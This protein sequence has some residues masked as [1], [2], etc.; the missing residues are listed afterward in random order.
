MTTRRSKRLL[1]K[2]PPSATESLADSPVLNKKRKSALTSNSKKE[3]VTSRSRVRKPSVEPV[4][5]F[6]TV[7]SSQLSRTRGKT[8]SSYFESPNASEKSESTESDY[9]SDSEPV[10]KRTPKNTNNVSRSKKKPTYESETDYSS[11]EFVKPRTSQT[12]ML[13]S[14]LVDK[15]TQPIKKSYESESDS[16]SDE[17]SKHCVRKESSEPAA[18]LADELD[19]NDTV[20]NSTTAEYFDFA[21]LLSQVTQANNEESTADVKPVIEKQEPKKNAPT[22]VK[23]S[24][25]GK[26]PATSTQV[27]QVKTEQMEVFELLAMGE[28]TDLSANDIK[29]SVSKATEEY[30]IPKQVEVLLDA[31]LVKKKKRCDDLEMALRRRLNNIRR[32]NQVYIHKVHAL[33]WIAHGNHVNS[34]L[35]SSDV[36]GLALSLLPSEKCYPPKRMNM[37]YL[38]DLINWFNK[39]VKLRKDH[40]DRTQL[41]LCVSLQSQLQKQEAETKLDLCFMFICVIRALG[42][43]CRLVINLNV[44]PI[45]PTSEQLLPVTQKKEDEPKPKV[46]VGET[47]KGKSNQSVQSIQSTKSSNEKNNERR[48]DKPKNEKPTKNK[49]KTNN[50][51]TEV[52]EKS[53]NSKNVK[54]QAAKEDPKGSRRS[55]RLVNSKSEYFE[56]EVSDEEKVDKKRTSRTSKSSERAG[57]KKT[58]SKANK[59]AKTEASVEEM[60]SSD[61]DFDSGDDFVTP[62]KKRDRRVLSSED[63]SEVKKPEVKS[64]KPQN[65]INYWTEV[66]LEAEEKWASVDIYK[67]SYLCDEDLYVSIPWPGNIMNETWMV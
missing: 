62:K 25:R 61:P 64:N 52:K 6:K 46:N 1:I 67:K 22:P 4:A 11:D 17:L 10:R 53:K 60:S 44:A 40:T 36:L 65:K 8:K 12:S 63:E 24:R 20:A 21:P 56:G 55:T 30:E 7:S 49:S 9:E 29:E 35:N 34:V 13:N 66:Y 3:T 14:S 37:E 39:K 33:C 50:S 15:L 42:I 31:P 41:D 43:K 19:L 45:K 27:P 2:E 32:E 28:N 48:M 54:K 26:R 16:S 59:K 18:I 38:E 47:S 5:D 57:V 23:K 58:A 51:K